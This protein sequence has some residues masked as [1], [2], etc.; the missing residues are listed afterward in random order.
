MSEIGLPVISSI[1]IDCIKVSVSPVVF[2]TNVA[3]GLFPLTLPRQ[4]KLNLIL[5]QLS[6]CKAFN[7]YLA[8]MFHTK[9]SKTNRKYPMSHVSTAVIP[10]VALVAVPNALSPS[11]GHDN[12]GAP[13][14]GAL[15]NTS[16]IGRMFGSP[17]PSHNLDN[18]HDSIMDYTLMTDAGYLNIP[19]EKISAD[20][21][22]EESSG[23]I[24]MLDSKQDSENWKFIQIPDQQASKEQKFQEY[25]KASEEDT[26]PV[27]DHIADSSFMQN[28]LR[29]NGRFV[30]ATDVTDFHNE[31]VQKQIQALQN[32]H[33]SDKSRIQQLKAELKDLRDLVYKLNRELSKY[34]AK[35]GCAEVLKEGHNIVGLPNEGPIPSWLISTKYLSPLIFEYEKQTSQQEKNIATYKEEIEHLSKR[36]KELVGESDLLH[37]KLDKLTSGS[38]KV[39]ERSLAEQQLDL[40]KEENHI[41]LEQL[42]NERLN[43]KNTSTKFSHELHELNEQLKLKNEFVTKI[44]R[45][46]KEEK[47]KTRDLKCNLDQ[48]KSKDNTKIQFVEHQH[49]LE[50]LQKDIDESIEKHIKEKA[51]LTAKLEVSIELGTLL[52]YAAQN[53]KL[54]H[55]V[56]ISHNREQLSQDQL[57]KARQHSDNYCVCWDKEAILPPN[58]SPKIHP[59]SDM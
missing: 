3:R 10:K 55:I 8:K 11:C 34:Q 20:L 21:R 39:F 46:F 50:K 31:E 14:M 2:K 57:K 52:K 48:M 18:E 5:S 30:E 47:A 45:E 17:V 37:E 32:S 54:L 27:R 41:L 59:G 43:T 40:I 35:F 25:Q 4:T 24:D 53:Q 13:L 29:N 38:S 51:E 42:K 36:C 22:D 6:S 7:L 58:M 28:E 15:M 16:N 1:L 33:D 44:E 23:G 56:Q 9:H 26:L 49:S 19:F 12:K